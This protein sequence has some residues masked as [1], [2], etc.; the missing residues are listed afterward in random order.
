[1][2]Q[3]YIPPI[4]VV[5]AVVFQL[6]DNKLL[7]LLIKRRT[8]PFKDAWALPGGY[9][10][11]GETTKEAFARILLAKGGLT[12]PELQLVEQ[13]YTFDTVARDPRGHAVSVAYMGL[14]RGLTPKQSTSTQ[15]PTF[16]AVDNLPNL[17]YDHIEIIRYAHERLASKLTYTN[18]IFTLLPALFS[19]PQLQSGYEIILGRVLDKRNF[20]KKFLSLDIIEPAD[21]ILRKG[22][23]RPAQL[24]VFKQPVLQ[25]LPSNFD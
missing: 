18:I 10:P 15:E 22:A 1:M 24:Y 5:D 7:V 8:E 11:E 9:N 20:R 16:F 3:V 13:L 4:L 19:L 25:P 6:I 2:T 21:K 12:A 17:A 23:H 14:G